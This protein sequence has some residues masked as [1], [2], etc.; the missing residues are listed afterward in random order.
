MK[1]P[2]TDL[3]KKCRRVIVFFDDNKRNDY[4]HIMCAKV[5]DYK[6]VLDPD[7]GSLIPA[8]PTHFSYIDGVPVTV[9]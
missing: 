3:P 6:I 9:V 4:Q 2:I 5:V 1:L 8:E 7:D